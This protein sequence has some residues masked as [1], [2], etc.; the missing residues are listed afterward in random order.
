MNEKKVNR[1]RDKSMLIR[2]TE[3]EKE[4]IQRLANEAEMSVNE[5]VI[6]CSTNQKKIKVVKKEGSDVVLQELR[7][8]TKVLQTTAN[9]INQI[10]TWVNSNKDMDEAHQRITL[11]KYN[12]ALDNFNDVMGKLFELKKEWS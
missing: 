12:N 7:T 8:F 6:H 10:A 3:I 4:E 1:K 5:Y 11:N 2:T 9:N